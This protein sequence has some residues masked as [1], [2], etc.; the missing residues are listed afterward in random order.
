MQNK[1]QAAYYSALFLN[2]AAFTVCFAAWVIFSV[3]AVP[4]ASLYE[5]THFE[6]GLLVS[7]P[8]FLGS[9][10]RFPVGA[11][12]DRWG[13]K[14]T[15]P[16]VMGIGALGAFGASFTTSYW[17]LL[18]CGLF[19]GLV[20]T[21]FI[22]GICSVSERTSLEK[23]GFALGIFAA[24]NVG[25]MMT[26]LLAPALFSRFGWSTT[27]QVYGVILLISSLLYWLYFSQID[28]SFKPTLKSQKQNWKV[29]K[30]SRPYRFGLYYFIT[31]GG[32]VAFTLFLPQYYIETFK[33]SLPQAGFYTAL[34]ALVASLIRPFGGFL[35]DKIGA[36][37][38]LS[39]CLGTIAAISFLLASLP[40]KP[41]V[42]VFFS[43]VMGLAMGTGSAAVFK[44]IPQYF[45][46][47]V[48]TVGGFVGAIGGLGGFFFPPLFGMCRDLFQGF[49]AGFVLF[50]VVTFLSLL[51]QGIAV[52][53]IKRVEL[54]EAAV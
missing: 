18:T 20:G 28:R 47:E 11:L 12:T 16:L 6:K 31:F 15:F 36:R 53:E 45:P 38:T 30:K 3:L 42:F 34:F 21:S 23:K 48:G 51:W 2:T 4:L 37:K 26:M 54:A 5:L 25:S 8:I 50:G 44:Y 29:I 41:Q 1:Q 7:V 52:R 49:G 14:V 19:F 22:V 40:L 10:L 46:L 9:V 32:F 17:Q 33:L 13:P 43:L 35:S 27:F 24:G 39:V